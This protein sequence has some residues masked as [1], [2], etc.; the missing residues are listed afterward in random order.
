M[1]TIV[2]GAILGLCAAGCATAQVE[3]R[4]TADGGEVCT[5]AYT[6]ILRNYDGVAMTACGAKGKAENVGDSQLSKA[7]VEAFVRGVSAR[8]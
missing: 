6:S 1:K 3:R 4:V 7:I 5:A 8:P 2:F